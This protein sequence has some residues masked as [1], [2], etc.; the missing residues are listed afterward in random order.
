[1]GIILEGLVSNEMREDAKEGTINP[2]AVCGVDVYRRPEIA[3][4][5]GMGIDESRVCKWADHLYFSGRH[6]RIIHLLDSN[7]YDTR[8][9]IAELKGRLKELN[10]RGAEFLRR[11]ILEQCDVNTAYVLTRLSADELSELKDD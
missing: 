3:E 2:Y 9:T 6:Y 1:M 10:A 8:S 11:S 4:E 5:D 7:E